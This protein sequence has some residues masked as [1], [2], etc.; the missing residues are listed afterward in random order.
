MSQF[1]GYSIHHEIEGCAVD[2][3]R[4][5]ENVMRDYTLILVE[6]VRAVRDHN[7]RCLG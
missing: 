4:C 6:V 3:D 1:A 5:G 7:T 2:C